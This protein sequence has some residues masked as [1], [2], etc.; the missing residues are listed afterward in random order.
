[1]K[2][3]HKALVLESWE[4]SSYYSQFSSLCFCSLLHFFAKNPYEYSCR[5]AGMQIF[6]THQTVGPLEKQDEA[7]IEAECREECQK[8][9]SSK[10]RL[11]P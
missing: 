1:M 4:D 5:F 3:M 6:A 8:S 7:A 2:Q 10:Q 9:Y 11:K